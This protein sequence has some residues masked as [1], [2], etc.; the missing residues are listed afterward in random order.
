MKQCCHI[1]MIYCSWALYLGG[2]VLLS[3]REQFAFAAAWLIA[4]P[5]LQWL[6]ILEFPRISRFLGYG[7]VSDEASDVAGRSSAKVTLYT[8]L[9]CPFCPILEQRLKT[10]QK[11]LGFILETI[12]VTLRPDL[13]ASKGIRSVPVVQAG[14]R[15]LIGLVTT[16]QLAEA[17]GPVQRFAGN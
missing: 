14:G 6:Y 9:G 12:D 13:V 3:W 15:S 5:L 7:P 2:L 4:G 10:L 16:K 17:I 1:S 11:Q 8:A